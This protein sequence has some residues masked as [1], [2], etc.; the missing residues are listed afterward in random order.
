MLLTAAEK[1][2]TAR[3]ENEKAQIS[4]ESQGLP[5]PGQAEWR[6]VHGESS[7][8]LAGDALR[9]ATEQHDGCSWTASIG[10]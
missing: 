10:K 8:M 3:D 7:M 6:H 1:G 9:F 5:S 4:V 2:D